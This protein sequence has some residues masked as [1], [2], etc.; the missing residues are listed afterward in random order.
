[1]NIIHI[2]RDDIQLGHDGWNRDL[3]PT[4]NP[5]LSLCSYATASSLNLSGNLHGMITSAAHN[6][7]HYIARAITK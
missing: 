3:T 1:M 6:A 2:I 4:L 7:I 5:L